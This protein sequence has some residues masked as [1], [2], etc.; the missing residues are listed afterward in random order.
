MDKS[1]SRLIA[2]LQELLKDQERARLRIE[3]ML[4]DPEAPDLSVRMATANLQDVALR[5]HDVRA[6]LLQIGITF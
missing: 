3:R 1:P 4:E 2:E 6:Q 5:L